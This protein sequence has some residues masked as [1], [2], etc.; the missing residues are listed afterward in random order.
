MKK[1]VALLLAGLMAASL[2]ACGSSSSAK[3]P[4]A[5]A[6]AEEKL[7]SDIDFSSYKMVDISHMVQDEMPADPALKL[8]TLDFFSTIGEGDALYN[9]EVISY[10][11]H[12]GTHMD[13]PHHVLKD[14]GTVESIDPEILI[15]PACIIRLDVEGDYTITVDD[16]KNWEA[17]NGEIQEGEGVM[18][19]TKH[20]LIWESDPTGYITAYPH[21]E[22]ASAQYLADKGV[23]FVGCEAISPDTSEPVC[24]KILLGAGTEVVENV[25]NLDQIE[26]DR[27]YVV[28]TFAAVQGSTGVWT[29]L[30]AYYK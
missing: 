6:P 28:A 7:F 22:E 14:Q 19:D 4:A 12:T 23:R 26:A 13:A 10:C 17:E 25:C 8:P 5:E 16:I 30:L 2:T 20:D 3:E 11:P 24:H 21:L 18:F 1:I 9:L 29:R 27:C 15:G